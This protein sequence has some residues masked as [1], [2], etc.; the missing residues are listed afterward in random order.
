MSVVEVWWKIIKYNIVYK[1]RVTRL[2]LDVGMGNRSWR[3]EIST[4]ATGE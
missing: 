4:E 3:C 1:V 2:K